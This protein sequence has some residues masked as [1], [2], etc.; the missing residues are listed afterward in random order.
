MANPRS[1]NHKK[2][3]GRKKQLDKQMPTLDKAQTKRTITKSKI[4]SFRTRLSDKLVKNPAYI[5]AHPKT[6]LKM[7]TQIGS[8]RQRR[9]QLNQ[10]KKRVIELL[11]ANGIEV[12]NSISRVK[13]TKSLARNI[14]SRSA[15]YDKKPRSAYELVNGQS[16]HFS[17]ALNEVLGLRVWV[18]NPNAARKAR[19]ILTRE[20]EVLVDKDFSKDARAGGYRA[21]HIVNAQIGRNVEIHIRT[22]EWEAATRSLDKSRGAYKTKKQKAERQAL[23]E[24]VNRVRQEFAAILNKYMSTELINKIFRKSTLP[25]DSQVRLVDDLFRKNRIPKAQRTNL[26]T[27]IIKSSPESAKKKKDFV[28]D[29]VERKII[30]QATAKNIIDELRKK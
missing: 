12:L 16:R 8:Y 1:H 9:T 22:P 15:K 29:L 13:T 7:R 6:A 5:I 28:N 27:G 26:I 21:Y 2:Q 19:E 11:Q 3:K 10:T 30:S 14:E 23:V 18:K 20:G 24:E 17:S 4:D 25:F